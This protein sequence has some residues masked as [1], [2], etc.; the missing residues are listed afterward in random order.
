MRAF[1]ASPYYN[2]YAQK[3]RGRGRRRPPRTSG[4]VPDQRRIRLRVVSGLTFMRRRRL[5]GD[6]A[7]VVNRDRRCQLWVPA[8]SVRLTPPTPGKR[9]REKARSR[10]RQAKPAVEPRV[11]SASAVAD[12]RVRQAGGLVN[13]LRGRAGRIEP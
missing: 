11:A 12:A 1:A 6:E 10:G 3:C 7:S 13:L 9:E 2:S 8:A 4:S 5:G